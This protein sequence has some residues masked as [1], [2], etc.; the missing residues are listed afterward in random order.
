MRTS[1]KAIECVWVVMLCRTLHT[2][3][4]P[5]SKDPQP[6]TATTVPTRSTCLTTARSVV[7]SHLANHPASR[8]SPLARCGSSAVSAAA[9][10]ITVLSLPVNPDRLCAS[11]GA[12]R[13]SEVSA[14]TPSWSLSVRLA[15]R[16]ATLVGRVAS[17]LKSSTGVDALVES[18]T[19][20]V[21]VGGAVRLGVAK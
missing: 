1:T 2:R 6:S 14:L 20:I 7:P 3:C 5:D 8:S 13:E 17:Q 10:R 11:S 19:S 4:G 16:A 15:W 21:M 9:V 12:S 18:F